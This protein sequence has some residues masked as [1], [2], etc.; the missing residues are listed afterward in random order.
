MTLLE[1][2]SGML[3]LEYSVGDQAEVRAR[4]S[5]IAEV[6]VIERVTHALVKVGDESFIQMTDWDEPCLI[7]QSAAGNEILRCV[8]GV[9][10]A[11][12]AIAAE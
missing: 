7:A 3:S 10:S 1:L 11:G 9:G 8:Y 12:T 6:A 5:A 2:P 4:L